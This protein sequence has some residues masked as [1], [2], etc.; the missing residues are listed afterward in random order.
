MK[1][2]YTCK[3]CGGHYWEEKL[4]SDTSPAL[5]YSKCVKC[6]HEQEPNPEVT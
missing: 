3:K 5:R 4:K 6:G 1:G 2:I